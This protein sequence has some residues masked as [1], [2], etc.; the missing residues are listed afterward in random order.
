MNN[1]EILEEFVN[2][3][4]IDEDLFCFVNYSTIQAIENL[5][6]ENKELKEELE[7]QI[8]AR[9][10]EEEYIDKNLI[11]KESVREEIQELDNM[12]VDGE[13]FTTSVN[14]AKKILQEL[15]ED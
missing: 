15:L 1:I 6:K 3:Y 4:N 7:R 12:K 8:K 14:F 2:Q 5:I 10:I 13:V 9:N 11:T